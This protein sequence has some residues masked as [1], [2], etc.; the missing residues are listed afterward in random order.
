MSNERR[1][2][3][4]AVAHY[5]YVISK[6][7][8][9]EKAALYRATALTLIN[10]PL[11]PEIFRAVTQSTFNDEPLY[12]RSDIRIGPDLEDIWDAQA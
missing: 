4:K 9:P 10:E 5:L 12:A 6:D 11:A 1:P 3:E 8:E 7:V 2:L